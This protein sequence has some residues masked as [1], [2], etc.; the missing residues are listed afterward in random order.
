MHAID[1]ATVHANQSITGRNFNKICI[2]MQITSLQ[3]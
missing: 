1:N 3:F 2:E